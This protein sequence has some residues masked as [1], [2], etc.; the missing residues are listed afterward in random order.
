[1]NGTS[2]ARENRMSVVFESAGALGEGPLPASERRHY[3]AADELVAAAHYFPMAW[4]RTLRGGEPLSTVRKLYAFMIGV[5]SFKEEREPGGPDGGDRWHSARMLT[6]LCRTAGIPAR[7]VTGFVQDEYGLEEKFRP[8]HW[9][10]FHDGYRWRMA[11]CERQRFAVHDA[12]YM[13]DR[14]VE[15]ETLREQAIW[16]GA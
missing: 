10:E 4:A 14:N 8:H 15:E 6:N 2:M 11:D 3:L 12:A 1:M 7:V 9:T 13:K 16:A 5:E